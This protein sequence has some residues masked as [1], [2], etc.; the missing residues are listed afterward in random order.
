MIEGLQVP[1]MPLVETEGKV[2]AFAPAQRVSAVPKSN[3]GVTFELTVT[4]NVV[5]EAH[6][7][8]DGVKV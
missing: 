8:A 5:G 4:V 7:P 6:C 1:V 3:T 2:G